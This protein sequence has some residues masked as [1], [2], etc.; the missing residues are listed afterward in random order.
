[1]RH[2]QAHV[3]E[4]PQRDDAALSQETGRKLARELAVGAHEQGVDVEVGDGHALRAAP[5]FLLPRV[6]HRSS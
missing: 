3:A 6:G 4:Q 5:A 1:V 2:D